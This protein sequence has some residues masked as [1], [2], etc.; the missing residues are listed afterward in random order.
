MSRKNYLFASEMSVVG[1]SKAM[2]FIADAGNQMN[3]WVIFGK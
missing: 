2:R 1:D 3:R